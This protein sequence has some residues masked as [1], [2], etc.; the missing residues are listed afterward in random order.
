MGCIVSCGDG[1]RWPVSRYRVA[2]SVSGTVLAM[3]EIFH[4]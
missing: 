2:R 3:E 4:S 1:L